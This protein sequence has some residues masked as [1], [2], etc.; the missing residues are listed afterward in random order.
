M[1]ELGCASLL[2]RQR[3]ACW[4]FKKRYKHCCLLIVFGVASQLAV[5]Q[6]TEISAESIARAE[7][8]DPTQPLGYLP[9]KS[10]VVNK[11]YELNSVLVSAQRRLAVINGQVLRE[12]QVLAGTDQV[13]LKRIT[14]SG[15]VLQQAQKTWELK[16]SPMNIRQY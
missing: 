10:A 3:R 12:G 6:A 8:R 13:K 4:V 5:T 11:H 9:T 2:Y 1:R 14:R 7:V 16:L 15:V